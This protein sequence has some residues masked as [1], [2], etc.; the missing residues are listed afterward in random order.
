MLNGL[1]PEE[2]GDIHEEVNRAIVQHP[3]VHIEGKKGDNSTFRE[4][5]RFQLESLLDASQE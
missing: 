1:S 5:N 4:E 2:V 3:P